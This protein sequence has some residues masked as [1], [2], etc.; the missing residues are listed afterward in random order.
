MAARLPEGP[1]QASQLIREAVT[2]VSNTVSRADPGPHCGGCTEQEQEEQIEHPETR[3]E[4][5]EEHHAAC[6]QDAEH[7]QLFPYQGR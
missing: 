1:H 7:F 5:M 2:G 4:N 6:R 3:G